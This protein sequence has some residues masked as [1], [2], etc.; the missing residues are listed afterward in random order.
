LSQY[1]QLLAIFSSNAI[2]KSA[3]LSMVML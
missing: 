1:L 3:F 2:V